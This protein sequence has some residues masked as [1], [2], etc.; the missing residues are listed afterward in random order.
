MAQDLVDLERDPQGEPVFSLPGR[1]ITIGLLLTGVACAGLG[2]LASSVLMPL[3]GTQVVDGTWLAAI[4]GASAALVG[5][6][7]GL[8]ILWPP[9]RR[10]A[11]TWTS[12]WM[13]ASGLRI[14]ATGGLAA[15]LYFR[16]P[17]EPRVFVL[18]TGFTYLALLVVETATIATVLG[19][20]LGRMPPK[21]L[22]N[23]NSPSAP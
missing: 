3:F 22:G 4:L 20:V 14:I 6:L 9:A 10:P 1:Q 21:A 12:I 23:K 15:L 16:S 17:G 5:N 2:A 18:V 7:L 13:A 11:S 8:A 19:P